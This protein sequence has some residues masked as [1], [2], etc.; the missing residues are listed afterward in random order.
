M[1][2]AIWGLFLGCWLVTWSAVA[3][4]TATA[5]TEWRPGSENRWLGLGEEVPLQVFIP[6]DY[7][8]ER[9]WPLI[10]VFHGTGGRASTS[11]MQRY[12][13]RRGFVLVG[14]PYAVPGEGSLSRQ[15][16]LAEIRRISKVRKLLLGASLRLD[17]RT[18]VGGFSKGGWMADLLLTEGFDTLAGALI[19]GAGRIPD[20]VGRALERGPRS[21][22]GLRA[23]P[24]PRPSVYIGIGQSD[25]N[26]VYSRRAAHHYRERGH[27]VVFEE[28]LAK[29]HQPGD[30]ESVYL[31]QWL[32]LQRRRGASSSAALGVEAKA[33]WEGAIR[34]GESVSPPIERLLFLEH[35][36]GAPYA[37][38]IGEGERGRLGKTLERVRNHRAMKSE[39]E[40]RRAYRSAQSQEE[41]FKR[42]DDLVNVA[43]AFRRVFDRYP[44]SFYGQRAALDLQR[45]SQNYRTLRGAKGSANDVFPELPSN[46][47]A[48]RER[49]EGF[50]RKLMRELEVNERRENH[51][52]E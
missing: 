40:A 20:D 44:K 45:L 50:S 49:F 46:L 12:T 6:Q 28:Y 23:S 41:A 8:E 16:V 7:S 33:W 26:H 24:T 43:G 31:S 25:T 15:G 39:M 37:A 48:L 47:V 32:E 1:K 27:D 30:A 10:Y 51:E 9:S 52:K 19:L 29:S 42:S 17:E 22:G 5:G 4:E 2:T 21:R 3:A 13:K 11:L 36:L 34:R 35:V 14:A 38:L 18:Y